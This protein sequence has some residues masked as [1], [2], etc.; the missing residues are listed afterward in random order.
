MINAWC[1]RMIGERKLFS[2][3]MT[4][5][6]GP[7][8]GPRSMGRIMGR[9]QTIS[10]LKDRLTWPGIDQFVSDHI[11]KYMPCVQGKSPNL[12]GRASMHHLTASQPMELVSVDFLGLEESKGKFQYVLVI[13]DVFTKY[14]PGKP[15]CN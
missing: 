10:S 6:N 3:F 1:Y 14:A 15:D 8:H 4:R 7:D 12:P 5:I 2:W 13:T 9:D 11:Q